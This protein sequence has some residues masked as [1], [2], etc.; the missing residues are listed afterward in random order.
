MG[1]RLL[2]CGVGAGMDGS[3]SA[4]ARLGLEVVVATERPGPAAHRD[5]GTV[6]RVDPHDA[7]AVA[8]GLAGA[9][10]T[11]LDG[12]L[13]LGCDNPP[14]VSGLAARFGC[15]GL[16]ERV[17]LDC[18]LKHRRLRRLAAAGV[19][20]PRHAVATTL[21]GALDGL[22]EL[23]LP[24]VVKPCDRSSS[25]GVAKVDGPEA[26]RPLVERALRLSRSG[27]I[28]LEEFLEGTE[29]TA[30]AFLAGGVLHPVGFADRDYRNKELFAPHFLESGDTLPT[31]LTA[32]QVREVLAIVHTAARALE[33]DPAVINTDVLRTA[34]GEVFLLEITARITGARI[35]TEVMPLSTGVDPLPNL[36]RLA[37]GRP[38]AIEELVPTRCRAVVQRFRPV[39]GEFVAWAGDLGQVPRDPRVHDLFW[40]VRPRAGTRLPRCGSGT[41]VLAG[42]IATGES[43]AE[44]EAVAAAAL[45]SLPVRLETDDPNRE[46]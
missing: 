27:R 44:A 9:G 40:G 17:A 5:A 37:L 19:A 39:D 16:P 3:V 18:T 41:D 22:R 32:E 25:V 45:R 42:V 26:A 7:D 13:S 29:H 20:T 43:V 34:D 28:V 30:V 35:A 11:G 36:A 2:V 38:L 1:S 4:L 14:A 6:L 21:R 46:R 12:V 15:P 31:A 8:A 24:A 10:I 33:L 23:G